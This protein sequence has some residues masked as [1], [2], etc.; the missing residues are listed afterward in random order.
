MSIDEIEDIIDKFNIDHVEYNNIS[1]Y[2]NDFVEINDRLGAYYGQVQGILTNIRNETTSDPRER[3]SQLFAY[4]EINKKLVELNGRVNE[5]IVDLNNFEDANTKVSPS[6]DEVSPRD[7]ESNREMSL[8]MIDSQLSPNEEIHHIFLFIA[9]GEEYNISGNRN[10]YPFHQPL[11]NSLGII[12]EYGVTAYGNDLRANLTLNE[13]I[14]NILGGK[15]EINTKTT[16][17]SRNLVTVNPL[18]LQFRYDDSQNNHL[19]PYMGLFYIKARGGQNNQAELLKMEH[20][21]SFQNAAEL[22]KVDSLE[23]VPTDEQYKYTLHNITR[24]N[25]YIESNF[26]NNE[27]FGWDRV[28]NFI[29]D[30]YRQGLEISD[31]E[32]PLIIPG[33]QT[34]IRLYT[35][36]AEAVDTGSTLPVP[37]IL[38]DYALYDAERI[39]HDNNHNLRYFTAD[40]NNITNFVNNKNSFQT[41]INNFVNELNSVQYQITVNPNML[42]VYLLSLIDKNVADPNNINIFLERVSCIFTDVANND[43]EE[44]FVMITSDAEGVSEY[45][46]RNQ[47]I[48]AFSAL[49]IN[50]MDVFTE[51]LIRINL[52]TQ[53]QLC[54]FKMENN[55]IDKNSVVGVKIY[56][57]GEHSL[58]GITPCVLF[59][60]F[61]DT[62]NAGLYLAGIHIQ[63]QGDYSFLL[64]ETDTTYSLIRDGI[65]SLLTSFNNI[66]IIYSI[67]NIISGGMSNLAKYSKEAEEA[68]KT[69]KIPKNSFDPEIIVVQKQQG[70]SAAET[71][72]K[73]LL[74]FKEQVER[75]EEANK[76]AEI[77]SPSNPT[78]YKFGTPVKVDKSNKEPG[79][80]ESGKTDPAGISPVR[81]GLFPRS[82]LRT[83]SHPVLKEGP[84]P[85]LYSKSSSV[86][87]L[88][89]FLG[90]S[91][92]YE[93]IM[94]A[95][96]SPGTTPGASPASSAPTSPQHLSR[97]KK[98]SQEETTNPDSQEGDTQSEMNTQGEGGP[99]EFGGKKKGKKAKK[100]K[101]A[102]KVKKAKK[103]RKT[104]K[105]RSNKK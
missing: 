82:P 5:I 36:R 84:P 57:I 46:A 33:E 15:C 7:D 71:Y 67:D 29:A 16:I 81:T 100:T 14:F 50:N 94:N 17:H 27:W 45:I 78:I 92:S 6:D 37:N 9:H 55:M 61:I 72:Y 103:A 83:T 51:G 90:R 3:E 13:N 2:I 21:V 1:Q 98:G 25:V 76:K 30:F 93:E 44:L 95:V 26:N 88:P 104:K 47:D 20:I 32:R 74:A 97:V 63:E 64:N 24:G 43:I 66:K 77:P 22:I 38:T 65:A 54:I 62:E 79:S 69:M 73:E 42:C 48:T 41:F 87:N 70:P 39:E 105:K 80:A 102:K 23:Q 58:Y 34:H 56:F 59:I 12:S 19:G 10:Y 4:E 11:F 68:R 52:E 40:G 91:P 85:G 18:R 96:N 89:D 28:I 35:C 31:G 53:I 8:D 49:D 75:A 86:P 99:F 60:H 101:R